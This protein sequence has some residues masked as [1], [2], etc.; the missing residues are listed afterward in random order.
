MPQAKKAASPFRYQYASKIVCT[1]NIPGTSQTSEAV[2]PG[3]YQTSVNIHNPNDDTARI[4]MKIAFPSQVSKFVGSGL[5]PDEVARV[6][7][8]DINDRFGIV[9]IHGF[10]GFLVIESTLSLDVVAVYTAGPTGGHVSSIDVERVEER[11]LG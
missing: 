8:G 6:N 10:E 7:C 1:A 9:F 4:R 11:K 3:V 5:K 2:L